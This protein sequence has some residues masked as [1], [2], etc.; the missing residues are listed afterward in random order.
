MI[1]SVEGCILIKAKENQS[2][3]DS[4]KFTTSSTDFFYTMR[5]RTNI[6]DKRYGGKDLICGDDYTEER[7]KTPKV[8]QTDIFNHR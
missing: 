5:N 6:D 1:S 2:D 3:K 8:R 7:R 4:S